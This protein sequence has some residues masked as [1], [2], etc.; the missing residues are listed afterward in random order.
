MTKLTAFKQSLIELKCNTTRDSSFG[1]RSSSF[2]LILVEIAKVP[3]L[4]VRIS[5][6]L[7]L[8]FEEGSKTLLSK[9][10]SIA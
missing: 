1:G 5:H 4:P 7:K 6:K 2:N 10:L 3:S 8:L 9:S